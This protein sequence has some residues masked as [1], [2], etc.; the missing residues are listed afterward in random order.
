MK[1]P[2]VLACICSTVIFVGLII[3]RVATKKIPAAPQPTEQQLTAASQAVGALEK[4]K[5]RPSDLEDFN[6]AIHRRSGTNLDNLSESEREKLYTC[7]NRYYACYSSGNFEAFKQFRL[8][9]PYTVSKAVTAAVKSIADQKGLSMKSDEDILHFAWDYYNGTN[10]IGQIDEESIVISVYTRHDLGTA[11]RQPSAGKFPGSGA[12]CWEGSVVYDPTPADLLKKDGSL[13]FFT[14]EA[15]VRFDMANGPA[16]PLVLLGY[17][18]STRGD[19]MPY[20]LCTPF[21]VGKYDTIF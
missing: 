18:D 21:H 19:W 12:L 13:R 20:A 14:L 6:S 2:L 9:P 17:W 5:T 8:L 15:F 7:I 4:V 11:L 16:T 1:R 3:F 10:N